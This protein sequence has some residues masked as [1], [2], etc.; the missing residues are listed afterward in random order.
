MPNIRNQSQSPILARG[1]AEP[2]QSGWREQI[3]SAFRTPESLLDY[4]AIEPDP[5]QPAF[6]PRF[7]M[8]VPE[9]FAARMQPGN[10]HDPLLLQVLPMPSELEARPGWVSDPVGD[11]AS[12]QARGVLHKYQGR[13]LLITTGACAINC[14]Y[15]FR[16]DYP[17]TSE[18]AAASQWDEAVDYIASRPDI[19]EVI[20]S[21]GDP[22]MLPTGQLERLTNRLRGLT[23]IQRLRLHTRLPIVVPDRVTDN[24]CRWIESLPWPVVIVLHANHANEFDP[25][26]DAALARLARS[27]AQL[28]NQSV[29][30]AGVNDDIDSLRH[31]MLRSFSA[32][33]IP[34]YLH[35]LDR[36][37]GAARFDCDQPKALK[38]HEALRVQ[39]SG[40]LVP[41]LVREQAGAPYKLPIL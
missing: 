21:G 6:Q 41:R 35:M 16:Q 14:R 3:R 36:V 5:G 29:L 25:A 1:G 13:V 10:R 20:L 32:R 9:A 22:L 15:C 38:L 37:A 17:Y 34:Y 11:G 12:R 28:F 18:H 31:L 23:H 40:Y 7:P 33:V 26:V 27:G 24:L 30:L 4:L 19:E 2:K 8:L 39:L